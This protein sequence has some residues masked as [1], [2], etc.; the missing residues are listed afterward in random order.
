LY[1]KLG[2]LKAKR[3]IVA[4]DSCFSGAGGRSVLAKGA[5]PLVAKVDLGNRD[6]DKVTTLTA[7]GADQI[8][9]TIE[10]EGHGAFTYFLLKGLNGAAADDGGHVTLAAL[11]KYLKPKVQDEAHRHEREQT[12]QFAS[13]DVD[14][15]GLRLR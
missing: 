3:V 2:A 14:A 4:L 5:R 11:F 9:G 10:A 12:P 13:S 6:S 1:E 8:S 7:S 15:A